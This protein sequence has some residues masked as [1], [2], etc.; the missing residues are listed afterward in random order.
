MKTYIKFI[1]TLLFVGAVSNMSGMEITPGNLSTLLGDDKATTTTLTLSGEGDVR[2]L[3]TIA[4]EMPVLTELDMTNLKLVALSSTTTVYNGL[5]IFDADNI[6]AYIFFN[7]NIK[8]LKLPTSLKSIEE[9]AFSGGKLESVVFGSSL[10]SLG[11]YA[12]YGN[13]SLKEIIL[14][15]SLN[16]IGKG[17]FANCIALESVSM[18]ATAVTAIP[19]DAFDGCVALKTVTFPAALATIGQNAFQ[20][21]AL[22]AVE[23]KSTVKSVGDYAFSSLSDLTKAEVNGVADGEGVFFNCQSLTDINGSISDISDLAFAGCPKLD[24]DNNKEL[25]YV[26][27]GNY[28][29]ADNLTEKIIFNK[30]EY[31]GE[32]AF[33]GMTDLKTINVFRL[34]D[35]IPEVDENA[36]DGIDQSDILL[37]VNEDYMSP[38]RSHPQWGLFK[39]KGINVSVEG[40]DADAE[41][42]ICRYVGDRLMINSNF[43]ITSVVV[44]GIDGKLIALASPKTTQ[45]EIDMSANSNPVVIVKVTTSQE[46]KTFKLFKR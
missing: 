42:I 12:F 46:E 9:G 13:T 36:F 17:C 19:D 27:I 28:S 33:S 29:F 30:L 18:S 31:V 1:G 7:S 8:S 22:T 6:P 10:E 44:N 43:D 2:D 4:T 21:T 40:V 14:P 39:I 24:L 15:A 41:N 16:K 5:K 38:W 32:G 25:E 37:D 20:N 23:I 34:G 11:E 35:A 45:T 26:A 3:V